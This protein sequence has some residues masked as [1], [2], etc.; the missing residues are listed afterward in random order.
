L[1][2]THRVVLLDRDAAPADRIGESL[3]AAARRLLGALGLWEGFLEDGHSLCHA[4]RSVWGGGDPITLD[5][6]CDPDGPGWRL[7]R[8]RFEA[9]LRRAAADK[10]ALLLAPAGAGKVMRTGTGWQIEAGPARIEARLLI[11]ASG[12]GA[13]PL[14]AFAGA[15]VSA[16]RLIC[17]WLHAPLSEEA[18]E[19]TYTESAEDGWWYSAPLP[20]G[21][22]L[23]AFHTDSDLARGGGASFPLVER[24]L[25]TPDLAAAI[26]DADLA[27]AGSMRLC[28]AHGGRLASAAGPGWLAIGDAAMSFDPL[29][30]QGLFHALYT[31]MKG[32]E[33][34]ARMLAGDDEAG[35][36]FAAALEPVWEAYQFHR[37]LYY[38]ME[39]RWPD[40]PFWRRRL[41]ADAIHAR[42]AQRSTAARG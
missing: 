17:A 30:S 19:I 40:A 13:R 4:R 3:P 37:A 41:G 14:R 11:D 10:G 34:A 24:A 36:A 32:G 20:D 16:D 38:G 12:R 5:A 35:P 23:L 18:A 28:A 33:A 39:R 7:D 29:S 2:G 26:A 42:A 22:R 8:R 1:A 27:K 6:M 31:G 25:A 21:R 9:R 15:P